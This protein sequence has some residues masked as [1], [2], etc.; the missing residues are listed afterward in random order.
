MQTPAA[1]LLA[2]LLL[3]AAPA[4]GGPRLSLQEAADHCVQRRER[5]WANLAGDEPSFSTRDL[6]SYALALCEAGVHQERLL[7]LFEL[8]ESKQD[9]DPD[10]PTYGNFAWYSHHDKPDDRNAVEF[11]MESANCIWIRHRHRLPADARVALERIMRHSVEGM[12]RHRVRVSYTNIFIMKTWNMIA[13]GENLD[14][15]D[16]AQEGYDMLKSFTLNTAENGIQEYV[17]PTYTA[18]DLSTL[19]LIAGLAENETARTQAAALLDLFWAD[20]AANWYPPAWRYAGAKSRDYNYL[21]ARGLVDN[22]LS[23]LGVI[24]DDG[25]LTNEMLLRTLLGDPRIPT[26]FAQRAARFPRLVQQRFGPTAAD[27]R[28]AYYTDRYVLSTAG[29]CYGQM[30]KPLTVDFADRDLVNAYFLMDARRD[31]YGANKELTGGG[32]RKALHLIPFLASVQ[33][34]NEAL[35]LAVQGPDRRLAD[36]DYLASH[37]VLPRQVDG[38]EIG[39]PVT[40]P[41]GAFEI[42]VE[43]SQSVVLRH[44]G[45]VIAIR[46][47]GLDWAGQAAGV[48]LVGDADENRAMRLTIT[49]FDRGPG[50]LDAGRALAGLWIRACESDEELEAFVAA[51]LSANLAGD[52]LRLSAPGLRGEL[53]LEVDLATR[54]RLSVTGGAAPRVVLAVD[55]EDLGLDILRR[56]P[57]V[58]EMLAPLAQPP[59]ALGADPAGVYIEAQTAHRI[60]WPMVVADDPNASGGKFVWMPG[61][62]GAQEP[63]RGGAEW[64]LDVRSAGAYAVWARVLTPTPADD[65]F[66]LALRNPDGDETLRWEWHTG[67]H[68]QWTWVRVTDRPSGDDTLDLAAGEAHLSFLTREGGA[69]LDRLWLTTDPKATPD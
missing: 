13:A 54:R 51:R 56:L 23:D 61:E 44:K 18:V 19:A 69:K 64:R 52:Q 9:L 46:A 11:S 7:R 12:K 14:L 26:D 10:S 4:F 2:S 29:R 6:F 3:A 27:T 60:R 41:D 31:P 22:M 59:I 42:S 49:H 66:Y 20:L 58:R 37:L 40:V 15:P 32:H 17:S 68:R 38:V 47:W 55:G 34:R 43:P 63:G 24:E 16:V 25:N 48:H 33:N 1:L 62:P 45:A 53:A 67:V 21:F 57:A 36:R 50:S 39:R 8:A 5:M 35:L 65:S 28:T 30:D